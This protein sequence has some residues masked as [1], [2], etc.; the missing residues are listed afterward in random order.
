MW[1]RKYLVFQA[2]AG[3]DTCSLLSKE[4]LTLTNNVLMSSS[5]NS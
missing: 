1:T 5:E 4:T 2:N 3:T